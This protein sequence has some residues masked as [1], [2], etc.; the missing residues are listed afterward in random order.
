MRKTN[1]ATDT[2]GAGGGLVFHPL[3]Q[4]IVQP[5]FGQGPIAWYTITNV[6]LWMGI[7]ALCIFLVMGWG[8]R[9]RAIVPTRLQSIGELLYGFIYKMVEDVTGKEGVRYF[10]YIFTI[11]LFIL[12]ANFLGLI[13]TAF[14][15]TSHIAVTAVLGF[16]VFFTVTILGFVL[17]GPA[18]LA[19]FWMKDA[20]LILRPV[21]AVIELISYFVRPV[22]HS[23]RLAGN[24][25]AGHAVI[26]VFAGF[27]AIAVISPVSVL[28]ITAIY[29]LEVLVSAIQAYVFTIL[30]C[31]YLKDALHPHH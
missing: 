10:P 5:L 7:A 16:G 15:P 24:V 29:G 14:T 19:L 8:T 25:M 31:V 30:T 4:F 22:S 27:A 3:D 1:V 21:I 26:K 9:Q 12:F 23:I 2:H 28:A 13:P 20:P 17:N 11:F 18:F 6:T